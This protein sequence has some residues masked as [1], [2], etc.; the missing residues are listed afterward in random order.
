MGSP[1]QR[2]KLG[3][4]TLD[5]GDLGE[6]GGGWRVLPLACGTAGVSV[7]YHEDPCVDGKAGGRAGAA[8]RAAARIAAP[9][10]TEQQHLGQ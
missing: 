8:A 10:A 9:R 4:I 3:R 7:K 1:T 6:P 2:K 5:R